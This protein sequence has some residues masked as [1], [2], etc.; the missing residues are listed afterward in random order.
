VPASRVDDA[1][2]PIRSLVP[3][4][5]DRLPWARFHWLIVVGL[6]VSW[7]LDG[8]EIQIVSQAGFQSDLG[9]SNAAVGALGSVGTVVDAVVDAVDY[10]G[11]DALVRIVLPA[12][13]EGPAPVVF[14]R[15]V[16]DD[17]PTPGQ[18]VGVS[19]RGPVQ[20]FPHGDRVLAPTD[21]A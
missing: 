20:A 8:L 21:P 9:L 12:G 13:P 1:P 7:I 6:G 17:A 3:A 11:H 5:L 14:S 15:V 19:V 2:T 16:G 18:L 4:R 10:F